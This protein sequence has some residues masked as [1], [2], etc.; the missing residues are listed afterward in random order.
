M[1]RRRKNFNDKINTIKALQYKQ[2]KCRTE[3]CYN[4]IK[5]DS[6]SISALCWRC[7][8]AKVPAPPEINSINTNSNKPRGWALCKLFVDKD[9]TVFHKGIEQPEL[10][11]TLSPTKVK[12]RK[13]T[14]K[15][16][17]ETDTQKEKRLL[18]RFKAKNNVLKK[19]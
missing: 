3:N 15:K 11:G 6:E 5:T 7:L 12:K 19:G 16:K 1:G 9:G 4:L 14:R 10:K 8:Q 13:Y 17:K 2:I 18:E